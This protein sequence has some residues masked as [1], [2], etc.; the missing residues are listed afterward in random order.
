[1]KLSFLYR[2]ALSS[3]NYACHYCPFAK[4][5]ESAAEHAK[6]AVA[7][8]KFIQW[9]TINSNLEISVFFTPWGEALTRKRYQAAIVHLSQLE[10]VE[11]VVIQT[12]L[13]ASLTWLEQANISK[14]A[15]WTTY[16]PNQVSRARFLKRCN[17]LMIRGVRF[18]V[19]G[20]ALLEQINDLEQL[21]AELPKNVYMWLNAFDRRGA[22]YYNPE[23]LERLKTI[24]P[25]FELNTK[26]Y[27]SRNQECH[28]GETV[29][30]VDE[31][32]TVRRCHFIDQAIGNLY[33][34]NFL[35]NLKPR[36]CTRGFCD[37]HIGYVH[38]P[39]LGL[40]DVFE[41]GILERIPMHWN[42]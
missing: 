35:E 37:C 26:R 12:N 2:G 15:L 23:N 29:I 24:D 27:R 17:E 6:D 28:A 13:S 7:L 30:T 39:E 32:G 21:R 3:C 9:V 5:Q 18:S 1:M 33:E 20:V 4:H 22:N 11:K 19:G 25:L 16:H 38:M 36:V 34:P 31:H 14:I 40:Y 41:G 10:H 8:T 42:L